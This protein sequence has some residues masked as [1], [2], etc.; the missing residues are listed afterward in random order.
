[1]DDAALYSDRISHAFAFSAKHY[2]KRKPA[3]GAM[4]Y[5]S[6]PAGI[7]VLLARYGCD[8]PT[9]VAGIL[10][11]LLE[12]AM[13]SERRDLER[14]IGA[15]F[16]PV[17]LAL[18]TDAIE[19]RYDDRGILRPWRLC[20]RDYLAQLATADPRALDICTAEEIHA[21]GLGVSIARRLGGEYVTTAAAATRDEMIWWYKSLAELLAGRVEWPTKPMLAELR[22]LSVQLARSL[23]GEGA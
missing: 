2:G 21:C 9:I 1:M 7:A 5:V 6:S 10:H 16:G 20:K 22:S 4:L 23:S 15:K 17:V 8:E 3:G 12:E 13:P 14:K 19:P 11:H 18:A